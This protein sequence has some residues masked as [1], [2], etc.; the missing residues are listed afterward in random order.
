MCE[1]LDEGRYLVEHGAKEL[2]LIAQD[3]TAYGRDRG[4]PRLH[5]L[6]EKLCRLNGLRWLRLLYTHPAHYYPDLIDVLAGEENICPYLDIP[7]QHVSD[8]MLREMGRKVSRSEIEDLL[9]T[10][11]ERIPDLTLRTTFM[12]GFPGETEEDFS[13]LVRFVRS[14]RIE[15]VGVFTYSSEEGTPAAGMDEHIPEP[16]KNDRKHEL[17]SAQMD[18]ALDLVEE[19]IGERTTVLVEPPAPGQEDERPFGRSPHEAPEVDPIIYLQGNGALKPGEF[20]EVEI[21]SANGYD[22]TAQIVGEGEHNGG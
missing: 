11:R 19:R 17:M 22:C 10:L 4:S 13:E 21:V 1:I 16:V 14:A 8:R 3:T 6:L 20:R 2:N 18:V 5:E 12:V 15:R 7:L 9:R